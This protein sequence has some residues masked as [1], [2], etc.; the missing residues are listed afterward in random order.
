MESNKSNIEMRYK[1]DK[2]PV[3]LMKLIIKIF[4]KY[5]WKH[6]KVINAILSYKKKLIF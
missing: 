6:L 4:F 1:G 2:F 5:F 3:V